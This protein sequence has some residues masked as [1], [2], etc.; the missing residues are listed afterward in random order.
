MAKPL[1]GCTKLEPPP[2]VTLPG[3]R[4]WIALIQRTPSRSIN[5]CT[6]DLKV[7]NAQR[8]GYSAAIIFDYDSDILIRMSSNNVYNVRIP[9]VFIGHSKGVEISQKYT[10]ENKTYAIL[11]SDDADINYLLIPFVS[12]VSI[13]FLI[14][15]CVF[16]SSSILFLF[17]FTLIPRFK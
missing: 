12:V 13:C 5:N 10:Y 6:F 3:A 4:S 8:A 9:S 16:V 15:I 2:N 11:Y 7:Y 17:T 1:M 14:A